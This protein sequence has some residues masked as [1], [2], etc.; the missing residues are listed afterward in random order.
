MVSEAGPLV[1]DVTTAWND[2]GSMIWLPTTRLT[3]LMSVTTVGPP[4]D[5]PFTN[6][7]RVTLGAFQEPVSVLVMVN[8]ELGRSVRLVKPRADE[9]KSLCRMSASDRAV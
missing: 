2:A 1:A 5:W 4:I 8:V 6:Q 7:V 3:W 9:P